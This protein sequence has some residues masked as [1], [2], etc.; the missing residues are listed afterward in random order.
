MTGTGSCKV[1][2]PDQVVADIER[3]T[4]SVVVPDELI[5]LPG[6]LVPIFSGTVGR[7]RSAVPLQHA[8]PDL[9]LSRPCRPHCVSAALRPAS[10]RSR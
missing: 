5:C 10:P 1:V 7:A 2:V 3:A 6:W 9:P 4:L 8:A